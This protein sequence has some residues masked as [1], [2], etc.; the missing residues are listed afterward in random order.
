MLNARILVGLI[1]ADANLVFLE[2]AKLAK[3]CEGMCGGEAQAMLYK[4]L[5]CSKVFIF[6]EMIIDANNK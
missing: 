1:A 4:I 5:S 3:V 6:F 2:T